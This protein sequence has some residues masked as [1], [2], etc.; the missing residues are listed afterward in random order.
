MAGNKAKRS[1]KAGLEPGTLIHIGE[2]RTEKTRL[3]L[4][5]YS[6]E[7]LSEQELASV[8]ESFPFRD[9]ATVSWLNI[10]GLHDTALVGELGNYFGLHPLVL[11]DIVN[12]EQRPKLEDFENYLFTVLKML[13]RDE[14]G[15]IVAEQISLVLG[16]NYVLSF[17]EGGGDAFGPVRERLRQNKGTL[18]KQGADALLYALIDAIVDNYFIVLESFGEVSNKIE[19]SL[20]EEQGAELISSIKG[21]KSELL[22]IR[23]SAW[24]L[25]ELVS[26]LQRTDSPLVG[27]SIR[28]YLRDVHDHA[29]QVM[30]SV[31]NQR[32]LL[33]DMV[34]IYLSNTS[35]RMNA[36]MKV[37]TIIATIFIPLT[38]IAGI[39]GMNFDNMPELRWR[40]GY[41]GILGVM[42]SIGLAMAVYFKRKK[43][44]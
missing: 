10:E 30:D 4:F 17:Q 31:E 22:F 27:T 35:N 18:R 42:A 6:P 40:W 24:P 14:D 28:V 43:W 8:K 15:E 19:E 3:K 33:S 7:H 37:L 2:R 21:L 44:F 9:T 20:I 1:N 39:Y 32:E 23:R 36:I 13:Y 11:E 41:F 5:D 29:V 12:T 38:F 16:K 26:N 34:D 25:R